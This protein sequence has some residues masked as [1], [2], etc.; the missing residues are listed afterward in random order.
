MGKLHELLAV[1]PGL[2]G[3]TKNVLLETQT[4]FVK[5]NHHF[6]G[7]IKRYE[8]LKEDGIQYDTEVH[9]IATSVKEKLQYTIEHVVRSLDC[10]YQKEKTNTEAKADLQLGDIII[11]DVPATVLLN[12]EKQFKE[13]R[14]VYAAI[15]TLDPSR[16]W[17]EDPMVADQYISKQEQQTFKTEK[18]IVPIVLYEATDKHPAQI[19]KVSKDV[20]I[21]TWR[22]K[23]HSQAITPALKSKLLGK[24]DKVIREVSKARQRA[25]DI[26]VNNDVIAQKIFEFIHS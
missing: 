2:K 11:K 8:P 23:Y 20:V 5:K 3:T 6:N 22:T 12:F 26:E 25:N 18:T 13:I 1:E 15:P 4:T 14:N 10:L 9:P 19:E 21:G 16:E 7:H 24:I 17:E